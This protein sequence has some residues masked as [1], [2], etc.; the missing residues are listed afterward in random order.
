MRTLRKRL[1][2]QNR[3]NAEAND[4]AMEVV[5]NRY[6]QKMEKSGW[7]FFQSQAFETGG[8]SYFKYETYITLYKPNPN[9][10]SDLEQIA[11]WEAEEA[12]E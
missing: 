12:A 3:N 8:N 9:S 4:K 11:K 1:T 6:I 10:T 7:R 2:I 5:K